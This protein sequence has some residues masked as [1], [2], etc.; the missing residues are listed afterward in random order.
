MQKEELRLRKNPG[1]SEL[2]KETASQK[3]DYKINTSIQ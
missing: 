1:K 3:R 2:Q